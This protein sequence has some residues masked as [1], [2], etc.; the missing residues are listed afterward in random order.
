LTIFEKKM[1]MGISKDTQIGCVILA[2]GL[3]TR[4]GG[5]DKGLKKVGGKPILERV[6]E[7]VQK[8]VGPV[9]IN[10]N[11]DG[12]RFA[13]YGLDVISDSVEG[14]VG[15]LAGIL[16]GM[17]WMAHN[18][19]DCNFMLSAPTDTP[20]IP[21][22]LVMRLSASQKENQADIVMAYSNGYD[23][24]VVALWS[25]ALKD[26]LRKALIDEEMRKIKK[27]TSRYKVTTVEWPCTPQ[28]PF[29]NVNSPEDLKSLTPS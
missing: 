13:H 16:A 28:D 6:L 2:G 29:F 10:A 12:A 11:G 17:Q 25:I 21:D 22:D 8:Q 20:F 14:F 5:G 3:A 24:P 19:S 26:D 1:K 23:H 15:P 18:H 27:W 9:V 4:M 7:C